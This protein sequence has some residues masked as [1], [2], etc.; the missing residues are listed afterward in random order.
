[1]EEGVS[2]MD[3]TVTQLQSIL[4]SL[5]GVIDVT[6]IISFLA[7]IIGVSA[8]F[9]LMWFGVRKGVRSVMSAVKKGRL[10]V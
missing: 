7:A 5:T 8:V 6:T 1:M 4:T 10:S 9:V 2:A 3:M